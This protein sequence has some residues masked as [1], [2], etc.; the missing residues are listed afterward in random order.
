MVDG[1][2]AGDEDA[3]AALL[4]RHAP[5]IELV[6]VRVVDERRT[7]PLEEVPG[8]TDAVVSHL[9]RNQAGSLRAWEARKDASRGWRPRAT[10]SS[11]L[12]PSASASD[13]GH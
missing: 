8:C 12:R 7:G 10:A 11:R 9:R 2:V 6:A 4:S 3:W 1:C 5:L 13:D